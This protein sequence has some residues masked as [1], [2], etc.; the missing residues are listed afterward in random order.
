M[1]NNKLADK[2]LA[3]IKKGDIAP[4]SRWVFLVKNY[5]LWGVGV[6]LVFVGGVAVSVIIYVSGYSEWSVYQRLTDSWAEFLLLFLPVFWLVLLGITVAVVVYDLKHTKRGYKYPIMTIVGAVVLASFFLGVL[7]FYT[8]TGRAIDNILGSRV[9]YYSQIINP[10]VG[11]WC[12]PDQGRLA[13]IIAS[14]TGEEEFMLE[15][16]LQRRW[17][18]Q[19]VRPGNDRSCIKVGVPIRVV[20]QRV[21]NAEFLAHE[22]LPM[23][24]G[25][26]FFRHN[27]ENSPMVPAGCPGCV[28][29]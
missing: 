14:I 20:G 3:N 12:Q 15:G 2:L 21:S 6:M 8:G 28:S 11:F 7:L 19:V 5:L 17:S 10:R 4:T 26:R 23:H 9:P 25:G 29:R 16:C 18:V 24:S 27:M 13:G 1:E 22:I